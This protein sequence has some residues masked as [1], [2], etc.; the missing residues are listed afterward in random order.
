ME[1][2]HIVI[3]VLVLV[4]AYLLLNKKN[5]N[6]QDHTFIDKKE[7][8]PWPCCRNGQI[9]GCQKCLGWQP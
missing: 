8:W 4:I 9:Y 1:T 2:L 7:H 3:A 6:P 5:N